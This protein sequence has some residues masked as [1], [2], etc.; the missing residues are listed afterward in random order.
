MRASKMIVILT[1]LM[2]VF[3]VGVYAA[4]GGNG[5]G[6]G[7]PP[8]NPPTP[9]PGPLSLNHSNFE[10]VAG[11]QDGIIKIWSHD[12]QS[13][14]ESWTAEFDGEIQGVAI[15]DVDDDNYD[16]LVVVNRYQ[17][18]RGRNKVTH[19]EIQ[20]FEDGD[21]DTPSRVSDD[22]VID[23]E[24][25]VWFMKLGDANNDG[26]LEIAVAGDSYLFIFDDDGSSVS[27]LWQSED[28]E[29]EQPFS[30]DIG[31]ADNDGDNEIV[32]A[33]L[34][35]KKFGVYNYLG[36]DDWGDKVYSSTTSGALDRVFVADIDGDND[37]EVI[38]GGNYNKLTIWEEY[39]DTYSISFESDDLGGFTQGISAGD[40]DDD[41]VMEISVG[42]AYDS[43]VFVFENVNYTYYEQVYEDATGPV[44]NIY[45]GDSDNDG[46]DEFVIAT[47]DGIYVYGYDSGYGEDYFDSLDLVI[48]VSIG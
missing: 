15:G 14:S 17:T 37:N 27:K 43:N 48:H 13:Y 39:N 35:A 30:I 1:I 7:K 20:I 16:E 6:N 10:I 25:Y 5:K 4:K 2:L 3:A 45:S 46:V 34:S 19:L 29:S 21:T 38:G 42:A 24:T 12:G 28:L 47:N 22:L 40:Y 41:D 36:N 33:G 31:D 26:T 44:N 9:P 32:Y 23:G 11:T 8:K 18:G